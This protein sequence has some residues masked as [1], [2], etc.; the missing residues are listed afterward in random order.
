MYRRAPEHVRPLCSSEARMVPNE[1]SD[2]AHS[3][4]E[5]STSPIVMPEEDHNNIP[6]N[7]P[8]NSHNTNISNPEIDNNSQSEDQPDTEPE[9][10]TPAGSVAAPSNPNTAIETPIP[11]Q[12]DDDELVTTHLLCC[13]D[14]VY[15]VNPLDT[16]CAW[17]CELELPNSLS[18]EEIKEWTPDDILLATSEKKQRTEV[19]MTMLNAEERK[20]F[21]DAKESEIQNWLKTGTVSKILRSKLAPEQILRCR[22]VL[23]W[24]P[25]EGIGSEHLGKGSKLQTHKPKARLVVLGYLDPKLTEVPRDSP[26]LGKQSKM[27]LLQ[28]IASMGWRLGSFDIKAAFLQGRPQS[29]RIIGIEPVAELTRAMQLRASEV[30][31]LEKSAY[32]LIDAPYLWFQTLCEEMMHPSGLYTMSL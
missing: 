32:G 31:Q 18:T 6:N 1:T 27:I 4:H 22:W 28:L 8:S 2:D 25:R 3:N 7:P 5:P 11:D 19:K 23:V 24:K 20:A 9:A 17:R 12:N 21:E 16:P 10:A 15:H 29:D 26:T 13:E 14:E 30:C